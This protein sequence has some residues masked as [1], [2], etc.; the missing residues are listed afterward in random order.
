MEEEAIEAVHTS[1]ICLP[2]PLQRAFPVSLC[3]VCRARAVLFDLS[4]PGP[5]GEVE[6]AIRKAIEKRLLYLAFHWSAVL[7]L[8]RRYDRARERAMRRR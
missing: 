2:S 4:H 5:A 3:G 8:A 1:K 7:R 6:T